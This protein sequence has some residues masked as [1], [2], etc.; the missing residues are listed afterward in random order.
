MRQHQ[1]ITKS[2]KRAKVTTLKT[3]PHRTNED[4][5]CNTNGHTSCNQ[6][7]RR[8]S[9]FLFWSIAHFVCGAC[10]RAILPYKMTENEPVFYLKNFD[11]DNN[12]S[13]YVLLNQYRSEVQSLTQRVRALE[14]KLD[15]QQSNKNLRPVQSHSNQL[16][17]QQQQQQTPRKEPSVYGTLRCVCMRLRLP[18]ISQAL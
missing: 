18:L 2:C 15:A 13:L 11:D 9:S 17:Q 10:A 3:R 12:E 1:R 14:L 7:K 5:H 16:V 6:P 8:F 4:Q